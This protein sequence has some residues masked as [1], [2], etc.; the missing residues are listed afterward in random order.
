[1]IMTFFFKKKNP[2]TNLVTII[3]LG[4]GAEF[5]IIVMT[6]EDLF[7][8]CRGLAGILRSILYSAVIQREAAFLCVREG[9]IFI[10]KFS[11]LQINVTGTHCNF[12]WP[13]VSLGNRAER[14][15]S[16]FY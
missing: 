1:M 7:S 8:C 9:F 14:F 4:V 11:P 13:L 3:A 6:G 2:D 12:V 10:F 5:R 15:K 16:K